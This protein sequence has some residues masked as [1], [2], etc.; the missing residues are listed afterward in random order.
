MRLKPLIFLFLFLI[1]CLRIHAQEDSIRVQKLEEVAI[2]AAKIKTAKEE[3][4]L[5]VAI[6]DFSESQASR[7]QLSFNDYLIDIPGVFALNA[8]NYSQDLRVSIRG[9]GARSAFGI[10]GI[11]LLVDGIPETT[12]DGQG[13]IDNLNLAA[14]KSIEV[15]RGP[16]SLLYGNASG[17]VISVNTIDRGDSN[18]NAG[19][20]IGNYGMTQYQLG[21]SLNSNKS[22]FVFR[23]NHTK[24]DGYRDFS[25]FENTNLNLRSFHELSSNSK[26]NF[27]L[28]YTNSP[29]AQDPGSLDE[30]AVETNR[31]QARDRNVTFDTQESVSQFKFG[32]SFRH[33]F[34]TKLRLNTYAFYA[35]RQFEAKL[36]FEFGGAIE[37][38]RNYFG[39]GSSLDYKSKGNKLENTL[40]I[41]YEL[42]FQNDDRQ[43]FI[44]VEG[45]IGDQTLDQRESFNS[46]GF[47]IVDHLKTGRFLIRGGLRYNINEL[48]ARD[49]FLDNGNDSGDITLNALNYSVGVNYKIVD[50]HHLFGAISTSFETPVL[51]ELSNNPEGEGGFN[52]NLDAQEA[53]NY[54]IGYKLK[55]Q[56]AQ[57][58]LVAFYID[59]DGDLVSFELEEFPDR[60]F[61]RNAG[62]TI[63]R[64]IE[65]FYTQRISDRWKFNTS[66]TYSD[67]KYG[68][69]VVRDNDFGGNFLPAIPKHRISLNTTYQTTN[70]WYMQ[71]QGQHIG[72]LYANDANSV[73]DDVYTLINV[74]V[75]KTFDWNK[76]QLIPFIGVNNLFDESYNDNIRINAF[77]GRYFEPGAGINMYGGLRVKI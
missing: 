28:N 68:N 59:T 72:S 19:V 9:F 20:I 63:R 54:E 44:N 26:L 43:R 29:F 70:G 73:K 41:G 49:R 34:H 52:L 75:R 46:Y 55:T 50:N 56:N 37:L 77:G 53:I 32:T 60:D 45:V 22:S 11:K 57:L 69:Y 27:Q 62:N 40:N 6:Q 71:L 64:G 5:A 74:R 13:Q 76:L 21:A 61:F 10:R 42:G 39:H 17:G 66:Y 48:G 33:K 65:L 14:L 2:T 36:P 38:S 18:A 31:R 4:P 1:T 8:N 15:I 67:F 24:T 51:S 3:L 30:E 7:Q 23:G 12:P 58:E 16:S 25:G 47:Y 35:N